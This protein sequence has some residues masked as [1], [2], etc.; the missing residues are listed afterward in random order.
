MKIV[1]APSPNGTNHERLFL[2]R[3]PLRNPSGAYDQAQPGPGMSS[4]VELEGLLC[5]VL[6]GHQLQHARDLLS[7]IDATEVDAIEDEESEVGRREKSR[8][9]MRSFLRDKQASDD[10]IDELFA[11]LDGEDDLPRNATEG[12]AGGRFAKQRQAFDRAAGSIASGYD[13]FPG[14]AR[15]SNAGGSGS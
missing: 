8:E 2:L 6:S 5:E 9:A 14:A 1:P 11:M 7:Q 12:D 4:K 3:M 15:I 10:E 13:Y